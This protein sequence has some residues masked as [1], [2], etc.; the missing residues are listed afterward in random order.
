MEEFNFFKKYVKEKPFKVIDCDKNVGL[1]I[2]DNKVYDEFVLE[3]LN[4]TTNY[5]SIPSNPLSS[6]INLINETL[7]D[8]YNSRDIKKVI[9]EKLSPKDSKLGSFRLLAKLH[10]EKLGF[11]PIIN[12]ISHPNSSLSLLID[13]IIQ[14]FVKSNSSYIQDS[15]NLIQKTKNLIFPASSKLFSCDFEGLYSNIDLKHA[16]VV[17][18]EF[19][20]A[21]FESRLISSKGF[22]TILKLVFDYNIFAFGEKFFKQILGIAMGSKSGPS[23][24]NIYI[25]LLEKKFLYIHKPLLYVR[26]ID[27]IFIIVT[28]DFDIQ[29]LVDTFTYL[30]LN[31]VTSHS[32]VFLDLI[33]KLDY[34]T[35][36]LL[37]SLYTKPTCTF[38]YLLFN[39]NHPEF[40]FDNIPKSLFIRI[41]RICSNFSDYLYFG[42]KMIYQLRVRGYNSRKINKMF[43]IVAKISR[44]ILI[45]YKE[46]PLKGLKSIVPIYF[47]F[48]FDA[49]INL[50]SLS[51]AFNTASNELMSSDCYSNNKLRVINN[52][53]KNFSNLFV[54]NS[55]ID[56][57]F[58]HHYNKCHSIQCKICKYSNDAPFLKLNEFYLPILSNSSCSSEFVVY[59]IKCIVCNTFY[60]GQTELLSRRLNT[61]I[62]NCIL[63]RYTLSSRCSGVVEHFN[64]TNQCSMKNFTFS[65]FRSNIY[66]RFEELI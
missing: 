50:M 14:P 42:S 38:S 22:Y 60:I 57:H 4:N 37:F 28:N 21:N 27:D 19:I 63:N 2:I 65:V 32:V 66:D 20:L 25:W 24:A 9:Y 8:L 7:L 18:S 64:T 59:I 15:Q 11:R 39:S 16:L 45:P 31:I 10:K 17:I 29:I 43:M 47:K 3:Q 44:D 54:H 1:C 62:R 13:C 33:I 49:N 46:K 52:M 55:I 41:R 36:R 5:L 53:Q 26:F 56:N 48:P 40:I 23:V 12:C 58:N 34:T 6:T 51:K 61:H 30:K 35:G